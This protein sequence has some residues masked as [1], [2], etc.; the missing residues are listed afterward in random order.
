MATMMNEISTQ[1][2]FELMKGWIKRRAQ[3]IRVQTD[4]GT[5][6]PIT[7]ATALRML[8][9]L[10]RRGIVPRLDC[11]LISDD[12]MKYLVIIQSGSSGIYCDR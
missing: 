12:S 7:K 9:T 5:A 3:I 10:K 1:E 11:T 4:L 2:H 6:V 8:E